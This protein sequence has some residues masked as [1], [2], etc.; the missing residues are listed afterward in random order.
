M[1]DLQRHLTHQRARHADGVPTI[2][3]VLGDV[4]SCAP[5]L[6]MTLLSCGYSAVLSE[7]TDE[8]PLLAAWLDCLARDRELVPLAFDVLAQDSR[9]PPQ[10]IRARWSARSP[11]EQALFLAGLARTALPRASQAAEWLHA[12]LTDHRTPPGTETPLHSVCRLGAWLPRL[13]QPVLCIARNDGLGLRTL[14][15]I[16]A[17]LPFMPLAAVLPRAQFEATARSI[18]GRAETLL[19]EGVFECTAEPRTKTSRAEPKRM[20]N[21]LQRASQCAPGA[22]SELGRA[23]S[24]AELLLYELLQADPE[25][26]D[27]FT[28]NER[29]PFKFGSSAAEI[30]LVCAAHRIA[31]EVDGFHHFQDLEA[32]R[33][34]RRKDVLLQTRDFWVSRHLAEDVLESGTDVVT[35]IK[36]LIELRR[37]AAKQGRTP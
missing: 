36:K 8:A 28:L 24:K 32:Y 3:I 27:K 18:G 2:T 17:R 4:A 20:T 22:A 9:E 12:T 29:M 14:L 5:R 11:R 33:R 7:H 25:T 13:V 34:D 15:G 21:E 37:F 16:S 35:K 10:E 30:D 19:R 6:Q 1:Q 31:V 26:R 23:R